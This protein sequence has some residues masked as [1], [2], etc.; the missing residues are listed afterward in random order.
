MK[1]F[2][3]IVFS[4]RFFSSFFFSSPFL[5]RGWFIKVSSIQSTKRGEKLVSSCWCFS[6][7]FRVQPPW[8]RRERLLMR[9]VADFVVNLYVLGNY[10]RI[11]SGEKRSM[12]MW[13]VFISKIKCTFLYNLLHYHVI[14]VPFKL[15]F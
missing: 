15:L 3:I 11:R 13:K 12:T 9:K 4:S 14:Y 7:Q 8:W 6:S 5:K 1:I 2:F 10:I